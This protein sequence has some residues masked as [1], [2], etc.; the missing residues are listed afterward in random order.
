MFQVDIPHILH[1]FLHPK[2]LTHQLLQW[3][4]HGQLHQQQQQLHPQRPLP[5]LVAAAQ[6]QP[7]Q[8]RRRGIAAAQGQVEPGDAQQGLRLEMWRW[9]D[10]PKMEGEKHLF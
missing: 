10:P 7:L 2:I 3:L 8:R 4:G 6:L 1:G 5:R 9:R